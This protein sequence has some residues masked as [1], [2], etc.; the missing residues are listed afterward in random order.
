MMNQMPQHFKNGNKVSNFLK[1]I[2]KA[3]WNQINEIKS[4]TFSK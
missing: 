3:W 2:P 4:L 1:Q